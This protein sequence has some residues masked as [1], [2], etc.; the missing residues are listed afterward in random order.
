MFGNPLKA[1]IIAISC[2]GLATFAQAQDHT[3]VHNA[4]PVSTPPDIAYEGRHGV[5]HGVWHA[6]F[7]SKLRKSNGESCCSGYDCSPTQ[8]RAVGDHY[9]VMVEGEWTYVPPDTIRKVQAPDGGA[10]VCFPD[11][12]TLYPK[13]TIFCVVLKPEG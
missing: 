1:L 5:G 6:E 4:T 3:H 10:H 13:G 7:Y 12:G 8:S 2:L 11:K 9:E